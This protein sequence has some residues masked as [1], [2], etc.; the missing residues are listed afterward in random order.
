[1]SDKFLL[2]S[3]EPDAACSYMADQI[4]LFS[5]GA[6]C[7]GRYCAAL[8]EWW[9]QCDV[10]G[11]LCLGDESLWLFS[12]TWISG[13]LM[14]FPSTRPPESM[15][16][17]SWCTTFWLVMTSS[18]GSGYTQF[19]TIDTAEVGETK[20]TRSLYEKLM[21]RGLTLPFYFPRDSETNNKSTKCE[22][23]TGSRFRTKTGNSELCLSRA[24]SASRL[25]HKQFHFLFSFFF[26]SSPCKKCKNYRVW[27]Y[28]MLCTRL[29]TEVTLPNQET[30]QDITPI[31]L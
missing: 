4:R 12:R 17:S 23:A 8:V 7:S 18:A 28:G 11:N 24:H 15:P 19:Y 16:S 26:K 14:F 13:R 25:I 5:F 21:V 10:K 6:R 29:F 1:M 2:L 31:K 22:A 20:C 27:F 9:Q 30:V 3:N